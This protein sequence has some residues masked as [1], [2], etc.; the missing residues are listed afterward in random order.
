MKNTWRSID[1][2]QLVPGETTQTD[3]IKSLGPPSQIINLQAGPV[4]Y[5]LAEQ[6]EGGGV[7]LIL[8][9]SLNE[10]IT[11]DRAVF[12]FDEKGA[13]R[14]YSMSQESIEYAEP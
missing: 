1:Q 13:L 2:S 5:Y 3:I 12:F 10:K 14:T 7:I 11:Y 6:T 9:N 4:F 8:F